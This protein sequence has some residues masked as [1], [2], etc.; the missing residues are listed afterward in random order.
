MKIYFSYAEI[1]QDFDPSLHQRVDEQILDLMIEEKEGEIPVAMIKIPNNP[2]IWN[3]IHK[4][5]KI[6]ISYQSHSSSPLQILFSGYVSRIPD[7]SEKDVLTLTLSAAS[8]NVDQE[9]RS[10]MRRIKNKGFIDPLFT[11]NN[12]FEEDPSDALQARPALFY[13]DRCSGKV[14]LSHLIKGRYQFDVTPFIFSQ[15]IKYK[16][17]HVPINKIYLS[18]DAFWTKE[19]SGSYN[20]ISQLKS[21]FFGKIINS[22]TGDSFKKNWWKKGQNIGKSGYWIE[23]SSLKE[24]TPLHTG[25]LGLYPSVS[26]KIWLS[27]NDPLNESNQPCQVRLKRSWFKAKLKIAWHFWQRREES[28]K[29]IIQANMS[30]YFG[31]TMG[32][33]HLHFTLDRVGLMDRCEG[34]H[35]ERTYELDDLVEWQNSVYRCLHRHY[36]NENF[37]EQNWHFLG[38]NGDVP[39]QKDRSSF[40][41]TERGRRAIDYALRIANAHLVY[42]ARALD[43]HFKIPFSQG[44]RVT[45]DTTVLIP[46]FRNIK[47]KIEGKVKN[48]RLYVS[49]KKGIAWAE[50]VVGVLI[51]TDSHPILSPE[52]NRENER[53]FYVENQYM[54]ENYEA[55]Q[56]NYCHDLGVFYTVSSSL[57]RSDSCPLEGV[58]VN[59]DGHEQNLYLAKHQYP[60]TD[61]IQGTLQSVQTNIMF[62]FRPLRRRQAISQQMT[63]SMMNAWQP[64]LNFQRGEE[65]EF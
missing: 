13:W 45:C 43:V 5:E 20:L 37:E 7:V 35:K 63:L 53:N 62:K 30:P 46:D 12:A 9:L 23:E 41:A 2:A 1:N 34:W 54:E 65:Y 3:R 42:S 28:I 26:D 17:S 27:P 14:R 49:G 47:N 6:F 64:R 33:R 16:C 59:N 4:A 32:E 19:N 21:C 55:P 24:I 61:S 57:E 60:G 48:C 8:K 18:L 39:R 40:F 15:T 22:L 25:I 10:L 52:E 36:S 58:F 51:P 31:H 50:V 38:K 29:G 11:K 44:V 56:K